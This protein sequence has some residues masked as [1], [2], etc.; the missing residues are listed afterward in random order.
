M[1][2]TLD[3]ERVEQAMG[4]TQDIVMIGGAASFIPNE[5]NEEDDDEDQNEGRHVHTAKGGS[6]KQVSITIVSKGIPQVEAPDAAAN[7]TPLLTDI[8]AEAVLNHSI[9]AFNSNASKLGCTQLQLT[10]IGLTKQMASD[11]GY[12][13]LPSNASSLA[14]AVTVKR[15]SPGS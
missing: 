3:G 5:H 9:G 1:E 11:E 10:K 7:D 13:V 6:T 15:E 4:M 12:R 2:Q 8:A 14:G